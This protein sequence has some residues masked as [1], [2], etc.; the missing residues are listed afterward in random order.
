MNYLPL[1]A[2]LPTTESGG[3]HAVIQHVF[4]AFL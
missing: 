1:E 3:C 2:K 4:L